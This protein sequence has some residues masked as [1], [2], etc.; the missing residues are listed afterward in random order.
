MLPLIVLLLPPL[1]LGFLSLGAK[2]STGP[3]PRRLRRVLGP[4]SWL[5]LGAVVLE[6]WA[7]FV[8]GSFEREGMAMGVLW[9][10]QSDGLSLAFGGLLAVLG[11]VLVR[12]ARVHL[13][14]EAR[15]GA[16]QSALLLALGAG[17][18]LAHSAS[19]PVTLLALGLQG[20]SVAALLNFYGE[21]LGA[22]RQAQRFLRSWWVSDGLLAGAAVLL[23]TP[24][25]SA[26]PAT[27]TVAACGLVLAAALKAALW[28]VHRWL[29]EALEVPAPVSALFHA[30]VVSAGVIV[31]LRQAP[32]LAGEPVALGLLLAL[33][34]LSLVLGLL[35]AAAQG[36]VKESL[37]FS[38]VNQMGLLF[39]QLGLQL[40]P[41]A[42]LHAVSH[43][44]YKAHAFLRSGSAVRPPA[45]RPSA[46]PSNALV[47]GSMLGHGALYVA[48]L[49]LA[50]ISIEPL[51]VSAQALGLGL[52]LSLALG[53]RVGAVVAEGAGL[54]RGLTP[55][56][57]TAVLGLFLCMHEVAYGLWGSN[58]AEP[59][60]LTLGE[61]LGL[62]A[63]V[64]LGSAVAFFLA[65]IERWR[66]LPWVARARVAFARGVLPKAPKE[67]ALP[68]ADSSLFP[69][70]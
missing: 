21:R 10:L 22:R 55:V 9:A 19:W 64:A 6:A 13:D 16:F 14:G 45:A 62:G 27:S 34:L 37:A 36:T 18:L 12:F 8:L 63:L 69:S 15:E 4:A 30:G 68:A 46:P 29:T 48:L 3:R 70:A 61:G 41:L 60:A 44:L 20:L 57:S 17:W 32:L 28:P 38:T 50:Q 33:G 31:L 65:T 59:G 40:W 39:V 53:A 11:G 35:F 42:L 51:A 54:V 23:S 24:V 67:A 58:F 25:L 1:A 5:G 43:G 66:R 47:L 56:L 52:F 26:W 7:L 49:V 2:V